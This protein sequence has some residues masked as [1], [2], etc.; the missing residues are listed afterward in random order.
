MLAVRR[1][2][3]VIRIRRKPLH[4]L[5]ASNAGGS[6]PLL[7]TFSEHGP[8][9]SQP[10]L[11]DGDVVRARVNRTEVRPAVASARHLHSGRPPQHADQDYEFPKWT[12]PLQPS[13]MFG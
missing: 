12:E 4:A 8:G 1:Y 13:L 6:L 9:T 7:E 5:V 10:G 2:S 3:F 11:R